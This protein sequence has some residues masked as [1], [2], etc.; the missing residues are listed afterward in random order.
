MYFIPFVAIFFPTTFALH[1]L[2]KSI[3]NTKKMHTSYKEL[4]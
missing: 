4:Q 2:F 3:F 1:T